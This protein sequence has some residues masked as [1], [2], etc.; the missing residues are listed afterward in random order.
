MKV[1]RTAKAERLYK[2]RLKR[3]GFDIDFDELSHLTPNQR[4]ALEA[5]KRAAW[6]QARLKSLEDDAMRAQM[7]IAKVKEITE[8]ME[9]R[10]V[11]P[12]MQVV[13]IDIDIDNS[14][15]KSNR[16]TSASDISPSS[17]SNSS[18]SVHNYRSQQAE[19]IKLV[20]NDS[21]E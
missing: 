11:S 15:E 14:N 19:R 1:F 2:E 13:D 6:R 10:P 7:V 20:D 5:E 4:R 9:A 17:N 8:A 12:K 21:H 18:D 3:G 16:S